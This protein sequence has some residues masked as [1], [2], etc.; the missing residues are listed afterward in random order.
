MAALRKHSLGCSLLKVTNESMDLGTEEDHQ[1]ACVFIHVCMLSLGQKTWRRWETG[2]RARART[3]THTH[4]QKYNK[5]EY[6][7]NKRVACM[8]E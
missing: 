1:Y 8:K 7:R 5:I 6:V 2:L 3:H 4:T